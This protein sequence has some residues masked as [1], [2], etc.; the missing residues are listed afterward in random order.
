MQDSKT[1]GELLSELTTL[2]TP[3]SPDIAQ[4]EACTILE[5][6][7]DTSRSYLFL[8][9]KDALSQETVSSALNIAQ[10]RISGT[11]L[12]YAIGKQYFYSKEFHVTKHTLIPRP[13]TETLIVT[14]FE[15]EKTTASQKLSLLEL[16][17]GTG[18]I[19]E[20]LTTENPEWRALSVDLSLEALKTAQ[21]NCNQ[22]VTLIN[23]DCFSA[24]KADNQFDII[25]SNPPYI[26]TT[27]VENLESCVIDFEPLSA[28]DGGDDGLIFYRYLASTGRRYLKKGGRIYLEIGYDQGETVPALFSEKGWTKIC[29]HKDLG[30]RARVVV[31]TLS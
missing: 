11:P 4:S 29:C 13:D 27:V 1:I 6:L 17:T 25:V 30:G 8:H 21:K 9:S 31:A 14:V 12:A 24:I 16:G 2:I 18:I 3:I 5:S 19:P 28:L 7:L 20:I 26:P 15:M 22:R 10:K 23:G